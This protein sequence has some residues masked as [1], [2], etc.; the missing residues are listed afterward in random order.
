MDPV[1]LRAT[2]RAAVIVAGLLARRPPCSSRSWKGRS[3][4][5]NAAMTYLLAVIG[6]AALLGWTAAA[7][8]AVGAF[9]IYDVLFIEPRFTLTVADSREWLTLLLLLVVGMVVAWL[10]GELRERAETR[11]RASARRTRSTRSA[12]CW[13]PA[14]TPV[15]DAGAR[16]RSWSASPDRV[17][18]GSP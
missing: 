17:G 4:V 16:D 14:L 7:A 15:G 11:R 6:S 10:A 12:V 9:L 8:T 5:D 1:R 3:G 2:L 13:R 18:H